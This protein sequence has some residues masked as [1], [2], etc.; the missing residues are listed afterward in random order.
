MYLVATGLNHTTAPVALRETVSLDGDECV[1]RLEGMLAGGVQEGAILSTCN[2][3]EIYVVAS[4]FDAARSASFS[5]F[6]RLAPLSLRS[7]VAHSLYSFEGEAAARHLFTV[8]GGL[9][10]LVIGEAQV[11]GQVR[12]A[13][14]RAARAGAAGAFITNLFNQAIR[15]GK[16]VR[17][18]TPIGHGAASVSHAAVQLAREH[19]ADLS[20]TAVLLVGAGEMAEL[21][22]RNLMTHGVGRLLVA[23]RTQARSE[24]LARSIGGEA[25]PLD[26]VDA[27]LAEVDVVIAS[28]GSKHPVITEA[29]VERAMRQRGKRPLFLID[30]AVPRDVEPG[31]Q[32]IDGVALYNV[33]DLHSVV[34]GNL[35]E[36]REHL[37]KARAIVEE[38][39]AR[40]EGWMKERKAAPVI[41]ALHSSVRQTVDREL[42]RTLR[43]L[44]HLSEREKE[45]IR[46][47]AHG[48]AGKLLH[49]PTLKLKAAVDEGTDA[50]LFT[51]VSELFGFDL[52][53]EAALREEEMVPLFA[54]EEGVAIL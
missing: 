29:A 27:L 3:T 25:V 20:Q 52:P 12:D 31:V 15:A 28:T 38:E 26:E 19:F 51:L 2:R 44:A 30:I 40:F 8:A 45:L 41:A 42:E 7:A 32:S 43:R 46:S 1:R 37:P 54:A 16:R 33:D 49:A 6:E 9:D 14:K 5:F 11:L 50:E 18:E 23:N 34:E 13:L 4:T 10:S 17:T 21:A 39:V 48:I 35:A 24:L 47:L 53:K 22:A 36:R